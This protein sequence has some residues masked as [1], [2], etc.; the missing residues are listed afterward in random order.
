MR[1]S[2]RVIDAI[3]DGLADSPYPYPIANIS[4][5]C[6]W[7]LGEHKYERAKITSLYELP[8]ED[9]DGSEALY[10]GQCPDIAG[11]LQ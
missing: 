10:V 1:S 3:I 5:R 7:E 6:F 2:I 8:A 11:S 9:V 4:S